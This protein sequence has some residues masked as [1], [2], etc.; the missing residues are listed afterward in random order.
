M[1]IRSLLEYVGAVERG[2][3]I[4]VNGREI[5]RPGALDRITFRVRKIRNRFYEFMIRDL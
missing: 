5:D 3:K 4:T 1:T 2:Q